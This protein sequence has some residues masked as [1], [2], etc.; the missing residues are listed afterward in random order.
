[1]VHTTH[2]KIKVAILGL[3]RI[4]ETHFHAIAQ[5]PQDLQLV[6]LCD[7]DATRVEKLSQQ[8]HVDGY[9][10]LDEM[11]LKSSADIVVVCT[12]SGMH[13]TQTIKIAHSGR[14]VITEKPMATCWSDG[15]AMVRA[16]ENAGVQLFVVKQ[17]RLNAPIQQL[18]KAI[19]EGRFGRLYLGNAN[20]FWNR[21]DDYYRL[22]SW[23][24][25]RRMDGGVFMN[26]ASHYVDILYYLMGP[27]QSIQ[28]F[29]ATLARHIET[30]DSGVV[31]FLF[32]NGAM[33]SLN[34]TMLTYPT[35]KEGSITILGEKGTVKIGG[36]AMNRIEEWCFSEKRPEDE[37]ILTQ[38]YE[39]N[40]VYGFSH[41]LV[42]DNV[43]NSLRGIEKP[44]VDGQEGLASLELLVGIYRSARDRI[45]INLPLEL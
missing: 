43:I 30:E 31:N 22:A 9:L 29:T 10:D 11:L 27:V 3:G 42:Y 40:S 4:S 35:D 19:Q 24:G 44:L 2:Q 33:A 36:V 7:A 25:T 5:Y 18:K 34:V 32:R 16:C 28:A 37:K 39:T 8:Y 41:P 12:P 23:R 17:N 13:P 45:T 26:Q 20:V 38:N 1:M 14:H 21:Q 6:A 15:V